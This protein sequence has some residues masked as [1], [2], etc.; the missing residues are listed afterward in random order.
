MRTLHYAV[1]TLVMLTAT[2]SAAERTIRVAG[3]GKA[4]AAPDM[5]SIQAG[6]TSRGATAAEALSAN[7]KAMAA[8]LATLK[9]QGVA[10]KDMQTSSLNIHPV[11]RVDPQGRML[12]E[13]I[14]YD[15]SNQVQVKVRDLTKLGSVLDA[16]VRSGTNRMSGI[17][18][19]IAESTSLM[20]KA[21]AG[22]I[23]DAK[24]RAKLYADQAG[25]KLGKV[26]NISEQPIHR[27]QYRMGG[28]KL[29]EAFDSEVPIAVG[30]EELR[31][32]VFVEFA[33]ED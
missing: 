20:D 23:D 17:S 11:H 1:C 15:V 5:A 2:I 21:R 4:S 25:V 22:A 31:A 9:E 24:R 16:V 14:G 30:E 32:Q 3:E 8:V 27:P 29:A 26:L 12:N 13:I 18:F 10:A 19:G 7:N 33:L 6:V 28:A